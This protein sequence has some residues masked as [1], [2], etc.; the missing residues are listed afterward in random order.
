MSE[1]GESSGL[2][3]RGTSDSGFDENGALP[4]S[5][6]LKVTEKAIGVQSAFFDQNSYAIE[7]IEVEAHPNTL[8]EEIKEG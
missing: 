4:P 3:K 2:V 7:E 8:Y 6:Q 1:E 5:K